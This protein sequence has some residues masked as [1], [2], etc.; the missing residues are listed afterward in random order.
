V[1]KLFGGGTL[2]EPSVYRL[3]D[4]I[5]EKAVQE[6]EHRKRRMYRQGTSPWSLHADL[7]LGINFC[8]WVLQRDGLAVPPFDRHPPGDGSLQAV[9]LDAGLWLSW[10]TETVIGQRSPANPSLARIGTPIL[11]QRLQDLWQRYLPGAEDWRWS[12]IEKVREILSSPEEPS[13]LWDDLLPFQR[14]LPEMR[15]F[16]VQYPRIVS[17][18]VPPVS[19]VLGFNEASRSSSEARRHILQ[20][21]EKLSRQRE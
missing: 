15:I 9:G 4:M 5:E 1:C 8:V 7:P 2:R 19:V 14:S 11:Q 13:R 17:F 20:A 6:H 12:S 10:F 16:C 3:C 18:V 21:A